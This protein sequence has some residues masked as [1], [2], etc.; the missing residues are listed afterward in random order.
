[1][2]SLTGYA[3]RSWVDTEFVVSFKNYRNLCLQSTVCS[4]N[5]TDFCTRGTRY[6]TLVING[7]LHAFQMGVFYVHCMI[8][9]LSIYILAPDLKSGAHYVGG[10]SAYSDIHF[11]VDFASDC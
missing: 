6:R 11:L 9:M 3:R 8:A 5:I 2:V 4:H 1:M 10:L 7:F